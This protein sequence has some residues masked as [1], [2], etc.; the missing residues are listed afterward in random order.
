MNVAAVCA[1]H[2]P[3]AQAFEPISELHAICARDHERTVAALFIAIDVSNLRRLTIA[4]AKLSAF[5]HDV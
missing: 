3:A 5:F 2:I 4:R 1:I